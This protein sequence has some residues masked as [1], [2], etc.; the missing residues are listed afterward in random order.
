MSFMRT[1][2][3]RTF[4]QQN[5]TVF[6]CSIFL[7]CFFSG[8]ALRTIYYNGEVSGR[9]V[10]AFTGNP[11]SGAIVSV[12]GYTAE[13]LTDGSFCIKEHRGYDIV[14]IL[15]ERGRLDMRYERHMGVAATGYV[16]REWLTPYTFNYE[17][18]I[19]ML[20][21]NSGFRYRTKVDGHDRSDPTWGP[22]GQLPPA[23][24]EIFIPVAPDASA[25]EK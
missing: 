1:F 5:V 14:P 21:I 25:N 2:S 10:D 11:I 24:N 20:P 4:T 12:V 7:I 8:C 19:K 18:P 3:Y 13:T 17:Q 15:A 23:S 22:E 9:V 16:A 6:I